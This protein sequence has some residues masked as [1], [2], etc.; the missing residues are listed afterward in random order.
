MDSEHR[1]NSAPRSCRPETREEF[2]EAWIG[3]YAEDKRGK[4]GRLAIDIKLPKVR[5][6]GEAT[7]APSVA[8]QRL[9]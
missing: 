5:D 1:H 3:L 2:A 6:K 8:H 9:Q 4:G 7:A